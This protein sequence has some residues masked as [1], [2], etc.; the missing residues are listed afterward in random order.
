M[1]KVRERL[2]WI[3]GSLLFDIIEGKEVELQ[4]KQKA[5]LNQSV[6]SFR[7]LLIEEAV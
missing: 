6:T 5:L 7:I 2:G 3:G 4:N 1:D